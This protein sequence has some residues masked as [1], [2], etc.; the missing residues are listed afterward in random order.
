MELCINNKNVY[1]V[2]DIHND[3]DRFK[4]L[5]KL[6]NFSTKDI[7]II[8]GDIFDRGD[9][10]VELYFEILK[11]PNIYVIQGNHDVWVKNEIRE[12]YAGKT[13]GEY[14]AYNTVNL[15]AERLT[16][17]DLLNL[18]DWIDEKPYY[19]ELL[20]DN[21]A[22]QLAHAQTY[23]TPGRIFDV[24][25]FYMGDFHHE[26]FLR[27]EN[28]FSNIIS[29]VGHTPTTDGK[30]WRS[31]SGRTVRI[32]CGNGFNCYGCN[33]RLAALRLNDM[34]EYYVGICDNAI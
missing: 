17:V 20:L 14:L 30:I 15:M 19:I 28:E 3:A 9:K 2:S 6:I 34:R 18:A 21:Q 13:V 7:L 24:K 27:G 25:K 11:H 16:Q 1:V 12:K 31:Q 26:S 8:N 4:Q 10:P 5:L 22:F 33:G 29:V 32:D 23:P